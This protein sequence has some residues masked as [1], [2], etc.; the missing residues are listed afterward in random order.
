[1]VIMLLD[2]GFVIINQDCFD[3]R[4]QNT[5]T[6]IILYQLDLTTADILEIFRD[7]PIET[8]WVSVDRF[9]I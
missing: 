8:G 6:L 4:G 3:L 2:I 5:S 9:H 7:A 1:M